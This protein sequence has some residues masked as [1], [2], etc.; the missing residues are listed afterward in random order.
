MFSLFFSFH[1]FSYFR[2]HSD[3]RG[4]IS[5]FNQAQLIKLLHYSIKQNK[6]SK[7]CLWQTVCHAYQDLFN[8][9]MYIFYCVFQW[10][11]TIINELNIMH[12]VLC[13]HIQ[14]SDE[15]QTQMDFSTQMHIMHIMQF[16]K[17]SYRFHTSD[18]AVIRLSFNMYG[19]YKYRKNYFVQS[20]NTRKRK[21]LIVLNGKYLILILSNCS[22][23]VEP[24]CLS[25]K[26][27]LI[28]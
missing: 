15:F 23:P 3:H 2:I 7:K 20:R 12:N 22:K 6:K 27:L 14:I 24:Y 8:N 9:P 18:N 19:I 25:L 4:S 28:V 11:F 1:F 13:I 5:C 21:Q 17:H 10:V 16:Q 26:D